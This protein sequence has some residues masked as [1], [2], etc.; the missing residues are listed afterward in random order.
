MTAP[1][2][3]PPPGPALPP[4]PGAP[5]GLREAVE[6]WLEALRL[7]QSTTPWLGPEL[8]LA[9]LAQQLVDEDKAREGVQLQPGELH[10][11]R[12]DPHAGGLVDL[13][14]TL[15]LPP[16]VRPA[17]SL[18][19]TATT[20][21]TTARGLEGMTEQVEQ[22]EQVVEIE[23][24]RMTGELVIALGAGY[25]EP[26][27]RDADPVARGW[28]LV[29]YVREGR[30]ASATWC[31]HPLGQDVDVAAGIA[32]VPQAVTVDGKL[33]RVFLEVSNEREDEIVLSIGRPPRPPGLF[34]RS[35]RVAF[36]EAGIPVP[37][38]GT[39]HLVG[40]TNRPRFTE[41]E[42][43][44]WNSSTRAQ[45]GALRVPVELATGHPGGDGTWCAPPPDA[46]GEVPEEA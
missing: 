6:G 46:D 22:V 31:T 16:D 1:P 10:V 32:A 4:P 25:W 24:S 19:A 11:V 13:E 41:V 43:F 26:A 29:D 17:D 30:R 39:V 9:A 34:R 20:A 27:G 35:P 15:L 42:I 33:G 23:D 18:S 36:P 3:V 12:L 38:H 28:Q 14:A 45:V 37:P 44:V 8:T 21:S 2:P 5:E 40:R 7:R